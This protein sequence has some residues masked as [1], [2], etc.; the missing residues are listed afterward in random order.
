[1][2]R[3]AGLRIGGMLAAILAAIVVVSAQS[4]QVA[5]PPPPT[6]PDAAQAA[7]VLEAA[8]AA[9]GGPK[10]LAVT[11]QVS[12]GVFTAFVQGQRGAPVDFIDTFVYPDRN[13]T[14]F[15]RK[16]S[17]VVQTNVGDTGW[18]FDAQRDM[19]AV[20]TPEEVA[21]FKRYVRANLDNILRGQWRLPDARLEYLGKAELSPRQ[22]SDRVALTYGD[23]LRVEMFFDVQSHLPTLTKYFEGA[24]S[25]APGAVLETRYFFF[26]DHGG[27]KAPRTVDLYRDNVQT[28][29]V[30]YD[31]VIFNAAVDGKLFDKPATSKDLK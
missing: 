8:T 20:Q 27:V 12:T 22:W 1:M 30:V 24:E 18:K 28:A 31:S 4:T 15:G 29:R 7:R 2:R 26:L 17:R 13:R 5:P 19:L 21:L 16:K 11:S 23:G 14:E 6:S 25:G 10:Y 9:L 3:F